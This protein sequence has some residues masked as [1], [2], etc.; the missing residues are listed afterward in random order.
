MRRDISWLGVGLWIKLM[1]NADPTTLVPA[2]HN[3]L[4]DIQQHGSTPD[5]QLEHFRFPTL[6]RLCNLAKPI[7]DSNSLATIKNYR[8][9]I[10]SQSGE[11]LV[12]E[13]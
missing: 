7:I 9:C 3:D 8:C 6:H 2:Q 4:S 5:S 11:W 13:P 10:G 12:T 1:F